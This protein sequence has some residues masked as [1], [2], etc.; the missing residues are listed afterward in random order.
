V[1]ESRAV[2][3]PL[4][5]ADVYAIC[6]DSKEALLPDGLVPVLNWGCARRTCLD[7]T[8]SQVP[9]QLFVGVEGRLV[10]DAPSFAECLALWLADPD[11]FW[12]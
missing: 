11:N 10:P 12:R 9:V 5:L 6:Q 3:F 2:G 8:V 1:Q 7:F 4:T